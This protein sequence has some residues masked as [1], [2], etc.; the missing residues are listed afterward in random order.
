[1]SPAADDDANA[2]TQVLGAREAPSVNAMRVCAGCGAIAPTDPGTQATQACMI[3]MASLAVVEHVEPRRDG[4]MFAMVVEVDFQCTSCGQRSALG[5][6]AAPPEV[7]CRR[8]GKSQAFDVSQ[9]KQSLAH[10]HAVADLAGPPLAGQGSLRHGMPLAGANPFGSVG[11][12]LTFAELEQSALQPGTGGAAH[13]SLRVK[14][15]TGHPVCP[16]KHGPLLVKL[17]GRGGTEVRCVECGTATRH[18]LPRLATELAPGCCGVIDDACRTDLIA[19][20]APGQAPPPPRPFWLLFRGPSRARD[21]ARETVPRPSVAGN[22]G[23][24]EVS[25]PSVPLTTFAEPLLAHAS[26][27]RNVRDVRAPVFPQAAPVPRAPAVGLRLGLI[28]GGALLAMLIGIAAIV[29]ILVMDDPGPKRHGTPPPPR[30]GPSQK[31]QET[32]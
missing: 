9:W 19:S 17:D 7:L 22:D 1:M 32:R 6:L 26:D 15:S 20:A 13:E 30:H 8:C 5:S 16:E 2:P 29:T 11:V 24:T 18:V 21:E 14:V 12:G 10:A 23:A 31:H 4:V 25:M 27:V 28:I 3:C